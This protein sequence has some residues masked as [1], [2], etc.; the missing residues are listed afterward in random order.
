MIGVS[1]RA[2]GTKLGL[3]E[4]VEGRSVTVPATDVA[5]RLEP[6]DAAGRMLRVAVSGRGR[7]GAAALSTQEGAQATADLGDLRLTLVAWRRDAK[8]VRSRLACIAA[9]APPRTG[10]ISPRERLACGGVSFALTAWGNDPDGRPFVGIQAVRDPAAPLFWGGCAEFAL[11]LV[12][13][14]GLRARG[15]GG[16]GARSRTP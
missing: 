12:S 7:G 15:P 11:T 3:V 13:F 6:F 8:D 5:L 10:W 14:L 9:G 4:A 1:D 16:S 2:A